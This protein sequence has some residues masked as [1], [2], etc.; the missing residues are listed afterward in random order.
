MKN[1]F[2]FLALCCSL[3][4]TPVWAQAQTVQSKV[5][6]P[7]TALVVD[8]PGIQDI[9]LLIG[10]SNMAGC[11]PIGELDQVPLENVLLFNSLAQWEK[12][13]NTAHGMN[14][15]S[16]VEPRLR[17]NSLNSGYTFGRK[18]A[19]YTGR[20]IGIVS[21]ARGGTR[22]SWWQKGYEGENDFNLYEEAIA[23]TKAALA[24][25]PGAELRGIL[26]HQGEGDNGVQA[27]ALYP[28]ELQKLVA[29]LRA[30]LN[31]PEAVFI[32]GEVGIWKGRGLRVNAAI[33]Q[34]AQHVPRSDF[35]SS[36]G[37]TSINLPKND[38]HF[39]TLSQRVLGGR[40][41]DK[42]LEIVYGMSPGE[43]VLYN[44]PNFTERSV[45]LRPGIYNEAD[46]EKRGIKWNEL[47]SIR[48]KNSSKVIVRSID[49][50]TI[51]LESIQDIGQIS[52]Q[53]AN[54]NSSLLEITA[55]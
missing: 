19:E 20:K 1:T 18:V 45:A 52:P 21:N 13:T 44:G 17:V 38:P 22:I 43:A 34:I 27:A 53:V 39:D 54:S 55:S 48:L 36:Q 11:A 33:Q 12:A 49:T 37:L 14:R 7:E 5:A 29:S 30:D 26:W 23:R 47:A 16:T 2:T 32:A 25:S 10:Q 40:Y 4:I 35:V 41:A 15:Y 31:A 50:K 3:A 9:Y 6:P 51:L 28:A 8:Q 46:L 42:I 24:A